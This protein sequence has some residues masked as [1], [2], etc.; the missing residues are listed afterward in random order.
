MAASVYLSALT[1]SQ[2]ETETE[3]SVIMLY[4][5]NASTTSS[6]ER[7]DDTSNFEL[8]VTHLSLPDSFDESLCLDLYNDLKVTANP[9]F[10]KMRAKQQM[11]ANIEWEESCD[12]NSTKKNSSA[13]D[14]LREQLTRQV[15]MNE[16]IT[17]REKEIQCQILECKQ[18]M[19]VLQLELD[20]ARQEANT[21]LQR[22]ERAEEKSEANALSLRNMQQKYEAAISR[23]SIENENVRKEISRITAECKK[24]IATSRAQQSEAFAREAA[25]LR[26]ARDY[27]IDQAQTM[28]R[29]LNELRHERES[30]EEEYLDINKE[31]ERQLLD[32]RSELKVKVYEFNSLRASQDRLVTESNGLKKENTEIN[33]S[34][35]QLQNEYVRLER[36]EAIGRSKAEAII[37]QKN[38][39]LE[40][41]QHEDILVDDDE[42]TCDTGRN[43]TG[44]KFL[45]KNS[46]ALASKCRKLQSDLKQRIDEIAVEREKNNLL[47]R[48]NKSNQRLLHELTAQ[49]KKTSSESIT[50]VLKTKDKEIFELGSKM[51]ALQLELNKTKR[52]RDECT[53]KLADLVQRRNQAK[54][55][56]ALVENMRNSIIASSAKYNDDDD[57][58]LLDH[59]VYHARSSYS[60]ER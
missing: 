39:L 21:L 38:E 2:V 33:A 6:I 30:K 7:A 57:D 53:A 31:L 1:D 4:D 24:E 18:N 16:A 40:M 22:A 59:V 42:S 41:Y 12:F 25:L 10:P 17:K 34:L 19:K 44:R 8:N 29:D 58:D 55:M 37:C 32:V 35:T 43:I 56:K 13:I 48:T 50:S 45:L 26:D 49:T 23:H 60:S 54:E 5:E 36:Q 3:I 11:T 9:S 27:A 15:A 47:I 14:H 46:I 20:H 52:E 51:N 28:E